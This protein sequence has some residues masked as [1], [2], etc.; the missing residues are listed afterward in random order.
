MQRAGNGDYLPAAHA[1]AAHGYIRSSIV[2]QSTCYF[3]T[4]VATCS[5]GK[6][7]HLEG[8]NAAVMQSVQVGICAFYSKLFAGEEPNHAAQL[9][10]SMLARV[11]E[12]VDCAEIKFLPLRARSSGLL[13]TWLRTAHLVLT[14]SPQLSCVAVGGLL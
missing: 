8:V 1:L 2:R 3:Y 13:N 10:G 5:R 11:N 7:Q 9:R 12:K 14:V 6:M 4:Q